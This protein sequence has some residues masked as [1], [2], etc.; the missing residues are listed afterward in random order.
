MSIDRLVTLSAVFCLTAGTA[1]AQNFDSI[2][3]GVLSDMSSLYS[4]IG[5]QGSVVAT[6]MA[7]RTQ[8]GAVDIIDATPEKIDETEFIML[9]DGVICFE[10]N[11]DELRHSTD[12]YLKSFLS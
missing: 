7:V 1:S 8:M 2:K 10:G 4:D 3:I 12:P 11:A 9:R 5:G 6:K